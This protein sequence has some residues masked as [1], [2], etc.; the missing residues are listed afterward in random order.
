MVFVFV[1]MVEGS[2]LVNLKGLFF[3][4]YFIFLNVMKKFGVGIV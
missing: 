3:R 2:V 1:L 4:G